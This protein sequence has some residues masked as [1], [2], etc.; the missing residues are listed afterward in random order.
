MILVDR[1]K[2]PVRFFDTFVGPLEIH[3]LLDD[4]EDRIKRI[5]LQLVFK[6]LFPLVLRMD[7][8][9]RIGDVKDIQVRRSG[10]SLR[11]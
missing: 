3:N 4:V 7:R 11:E 8:L 1:H 10:N 5:L 6:P 2:G 9:D